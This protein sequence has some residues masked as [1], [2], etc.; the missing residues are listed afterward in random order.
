MAV[1]Y[2]TKAFV[3]SL[4]E[5]LHEEAK[6]HGV[7]VT[8]LC[9]GPTRTEFGDVAGFSE[10]AAL[11]SVSMDAE[12]VVR[13]GLAALEANDAVVITGALNRVVAFSTRLAPRSLARKVAGALNL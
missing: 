3:L 10:S 2:A 9:P 12:P 5:A 11:T 1:Y 8:A 6:P 7:R 4:S 13:K